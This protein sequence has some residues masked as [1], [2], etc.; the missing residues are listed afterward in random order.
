[1]MYSFNLVFLGLGG[2]VDLNR[3]SR[4][5]DGA[6]EGLVFRLEVLKLAVPKRRTIEIRCFFASISDCGREHN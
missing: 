5:D 6:L 1:M 3:L 4:P 2:K